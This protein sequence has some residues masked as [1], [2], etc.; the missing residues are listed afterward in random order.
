MLLTS[1]T[2]KA[3]ITIKNNHNNADGGIGSR[4]NANQETIRRKITILLTKSHIFI[5]FIALYIL[6][7]IYFLDVY[8]KVL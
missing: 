4:I 5:F 7:S 1:K 2:K 3:A 8:K 6:C